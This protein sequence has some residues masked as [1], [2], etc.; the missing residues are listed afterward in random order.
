VCQDTFDKHKDL[1]VAQVKDGCAGLRMVD[2]ELTTFSSAFRWGVRKN[3][4]RWN[5]AA[6][7][8]FFSDKKKAKKAKDRTPHD[9]DE[10]HKFAET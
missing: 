8:I 6:E 4:A 10:L 7:R 5:P 3:M 2:R 9:L 1:R